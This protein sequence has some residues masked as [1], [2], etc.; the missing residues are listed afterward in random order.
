MK[1]NIRS[2]ITG[3]GSYIPEQRIPNADFESQTFLNA[4]G[5]PFEKDTKEI[6]RKFEEITGI[7][8]R[9][10]ASYDLLA[11]DMGALAAKKALKSAGIERES[12]D[13]II[14]AHNF[15][16]IR[17]DN[18]RVDMLP[19]LAARIKHKL[20]INN[21]SCVAYDLPFG[22]PGWLQGI[23]QGH[24]YL[25]SGEVSKVL[26]IGAE[27]LSRVCDP[28][29]RD[30]MIYAD[31]AG[32]TI[33]EAK[34]HDSPTGILAH[35]TRSDTLEQAY[36]LNMGKSYHPESDDTL[37]LKMEGRKLYH[38][39]LTHVPQ[40]IKSCLAKAETGLDQVDKI[41]MHQANG[42]MDKAILDRLFTLCDMGSPPNGSI[43]PMTIS[44]LGNTSVATIPTLFDLIIRNKMEGHEIKT[45]DIVV[46]ASVGGGMNIN[47][48]VYRH[49]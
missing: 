31:G 46:F 15:G 20:G 36:Y 41:L 3:T 49:E 7:K 45:G 4:D 21:P 17:P 5:K 16:D 27:T 25:T 29:D 30:S 48:V 19:S 18:R 23:I 33:L 47:S 38:Y 24:Y 11:S 2:I 26:V 28:Y 40:A 12:L 13:Y 44:W 32:A 39:A 10:Y 37:Y 9:R 6:I 8:E 43:M 14:V 42:K 22:C 34:E 35:S 1:Q